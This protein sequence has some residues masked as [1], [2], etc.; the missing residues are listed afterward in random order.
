MC[1]RTSGLPDD[2]NKLTRSIDGQLNNYFYVTLINLISLIY[3]GLFLYLGLM[4]SFSKR[5]SKIVYHHNARRGSFE[6]NED[7]DYRSV[8]ES[9]TEQTNDNPIEDTAV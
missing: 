4:N 7:R 8:G 9:E 2:V 5:L 1:R 3:G 6:D